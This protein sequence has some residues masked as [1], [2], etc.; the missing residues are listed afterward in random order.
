[1]KESPFFCEGLHPLTWELIPAQ[2]N[3]TLQRTYVKEEEKLRKGKEAGHYARRIWFFINPP[4]RVPS[5][6][7]RTRNAERKSVS[8]YSSIHRL[9]RSHVYYYYYYLTK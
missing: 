7:S 6:S 4:F 1:L 2:L 9:C 3:Q 5:L 8:T